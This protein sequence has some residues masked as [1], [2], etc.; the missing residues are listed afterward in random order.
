MKGKN[1]IFCGNH[2][3]GNTTDFFCSAYCKALVCEVVK[4][5]LSTLSDGALWSLV[6][7]FGLGRAVKR[8]YYGA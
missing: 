2:F 6:V 1:C 8:K 7:E 3:D 5:H 4:D